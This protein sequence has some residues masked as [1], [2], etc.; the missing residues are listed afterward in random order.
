MVHMTAPP[1]HPVSQQ[2]CWCYSSYNVEINM[3]SCHISKQDK[4][5]VRKYSIELSHNSYGFQFVLVRRERNFMSVI[6]KLFPR[7][8]VWPIFSGKKI[9]RR[10]LWLLSLYGRKN[11]P[12][13]GM[14]GNEIG[15]F[16]GSMFEWLLVG[17]DILY[18]G[19]LYL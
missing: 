2:G 1:W 4:V 16:L 11:I 3:F 18:L 17:Q 13:R 14:D 15:H 12:V 9:Q 6:T 7:K 19:C 5:L 10:S 8:F